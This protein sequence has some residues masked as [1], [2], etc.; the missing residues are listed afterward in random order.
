M[1]LMRKTNSQAGF[2]LIEV[3]L[4]VMIIGVLAAIVLPSF[5]LDAAR[6]KVSEAVLAFGPC[7]DAVS[8]G[9]ITGGPLPTVWGCESSG[10]VSQYVGSVTVDPNGVITVGLQGFNDLRLDTFDITMVPEDNTGRALTQDDSGN[11]VTRWR[12]GSPPGTTLDPKYLPASC[13]G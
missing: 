2:T 1:R 9:Y 4:V 8:E 13:R 10:R 3:M 11:G 5:R 6:A 7:K 12:C